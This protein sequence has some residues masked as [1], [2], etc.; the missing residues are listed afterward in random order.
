MDTFRSVYRGKTNIF[1]YFLQKYIGEYSKTWNQWI[2]CPETGDLL[3]S[4]S[5]KDR[6]A[7]CN[8][9]HHFNYYDLINA[10]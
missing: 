1:Y 10:I 5:D 9:V 6:S 8:K 4:F 2:I 3:I 7:F